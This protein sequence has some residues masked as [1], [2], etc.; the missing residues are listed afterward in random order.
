MTIGIPVLPG[1]HR[2]EAI[3]GRLQA[4][5]FKTCI[6]HIAG[7]TRYAAASGIP[8]ALRIWHRPIAA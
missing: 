5:P 6:L 4:T 8:R 7:A 1:W 3:A 2:K